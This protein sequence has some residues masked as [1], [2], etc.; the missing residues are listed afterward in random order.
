M[1]P[2]RM[3]TKWCVVS[4][5]WTVLV[6]A[7]TANADSIV[8]PGEKLQK[9]AGDFEFTEGPACDAAGAV[10]FT[11]QPNDR[12]LK[13][14]VDGELTTFMQPA[15][16]ANGLCFDGD[17]DL[18]ACADGKNELWKISPEKKVEVVLTGIDGGLFNGPNDIWIAPDGG[19]YFTDPYYRRNYWP[20]GR[21]R[22]I[23]ERVYHVASGSVKPVAVAD[24]LRQPNGIIGTPDGKFLYVSD[25]GARRIYRYNIQD[26]GSLRDKS[27]FC[28][29]GSDGM[30]IDSEGNVYLTNERGVTVFDPGGRQIDNIPVPERWTAN[31][32]FGGA[33]RRM[34]FITASRGLY[35]IRTRVNGVG[36]Q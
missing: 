25:I 13:W 32:C 2:A 6:V 30:T 34:L 36:S 28:E 24:D 22:R 11:D 23:P 35:G 26:D 18:W 20:R 9:L 4:A 5:L 3:A 29:M 16:R 12:I 10:F 15:G 17:G 8:E 31:V 33:D 1:N 14:S 21:A 19:Y 7:A 27:L